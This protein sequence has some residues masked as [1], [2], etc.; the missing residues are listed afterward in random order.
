MCPQTDLEAYIETTKGDKTSRDI[1]LLGLPGALN[2]QI[3]DNFRFMKY[4]DFGNEYS[5]F[6]GGI[7]I[8]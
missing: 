2:G 4:E 7:D 5:R 1:V 3:F 6:Y 8:G